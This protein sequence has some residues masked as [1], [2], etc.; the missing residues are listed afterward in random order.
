M[1]IQRVLGAYFSA[2]GTTQRI[3]E[4][5]A[6]DLSALLSIPVQ[7]HDFTLPEKREAALPLE[8]TDLVVFGT[9][10]YAGRV[11][12]VLL[13][14]IRHCVLGSHTL[15]VPIVVYGNR[16]YD[17]ALIELRDL[18]ERNGFHTI[19]A[20]AFIGEH[21]F[22]NCLGANRPDESDLKIAHQ[23][24]KRISD[25]VQT[26]KSKPTQPIWVKGNMPLQPYYVPRDREG[27]QVNILKV[28][29]ETNEKC[30]Q[31]GICI[32][33]CPMGSISKEDAHIITGICIKCGSCVKKCPVG[34]KYYTDE[35]YLYHKRELEELY[36]RR[37]EP[38][39]F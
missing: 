16:N 30:T 38:E 18:L 14:Y 34:A 11:P 21:A 15:A 29:P 39:I 24:A 6:H 35:K 26:M 33:A 9:P 1:I 25:Q 4:T 37:A 5:I 23:L 10:V 19:A 2:T 31:C 3:V 12:N 8:P 7:I 20:G 28:H 36:A 22:S 27:K 17:D 32:A 13:P